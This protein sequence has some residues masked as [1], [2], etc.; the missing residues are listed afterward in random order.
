MDPYGTIS[1]EQGQRIGRDYTRG[2]GRISAAVERRTAQVPS[3]A[4]LGLAGASII[5]SLALFIMARREPA[6]FVGTWAPTF[7]ILGLY[8][9]LVR[10]EEVQKAMRAS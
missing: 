4:Y 1:S 5:G 9:K 3:L 2:E 8:H 7:L 6:I 10:Q